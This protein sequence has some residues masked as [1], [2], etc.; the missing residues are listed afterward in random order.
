M[1][2]SQDGG[3]SARDIPKTAL[4]ATPIQRQVLREGTRDVGWVDGSRTSCFSD[5]DLRLR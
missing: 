1:Q 2:D 5:L 3:E 4:I